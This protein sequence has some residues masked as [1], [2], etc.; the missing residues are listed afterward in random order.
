MQAGWRCTCSHECLGE[1]SAVELAGVLDV[2][3]HKYVAQ[4]SKLPMRKRGF[5]LQVS[6][7]IASWLAAPACGMHARLQ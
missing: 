7:G 2:V 4:L 6:G 1:A 5:V 3:G